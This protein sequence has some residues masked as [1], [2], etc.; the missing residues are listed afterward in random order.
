MRRMPREF[1]R[2]LDAKRSSLSAAEIN[3]I[4]RRLGIVLLR[5]V[6]TMESN[7]GDSPLRVA[8]RDSLKPVCDYM[9]HFDVSDL[10]VEDDNGSEA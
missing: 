4:V 8:V 9:I 2:R 6:E 1:A 10:E 7:L 3:T 5:A